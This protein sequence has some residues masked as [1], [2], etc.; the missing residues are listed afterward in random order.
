M[1]NKI[2]NYII[3]FL[4]S[5]LKRRRLWTG[6]ELCWWLIMVARPRHPVIP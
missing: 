3:I 2:G 6:R 4:R 1:L 5:V